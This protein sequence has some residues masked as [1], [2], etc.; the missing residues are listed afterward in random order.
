MTF[1]IIVPVY[2]VK[3]YL[4]AALD[5]LMAQEE[6][7]AE[8]I[9]IDDGSTDGS[10]TILEQYVLKDDRF[11]L[12]TGP[13]GGYGKAMNRG[14]EQA[15]G[16]YIGILEPDDLFVDDCL[17]LIKRR[18]GAD[19]IKGNFSLFWENPPREEE[20]KLKSAQWGSGTPL[21]NPN[22]LVNNPS[23]WSAFYKRSFLEANHI[24]F[25]ET[26]GASFQDLPFF[27]ETFLQAESLYVMED[28]LYRYRQTNPASS[29]KKKNDSQ[30]ILDLYRRIQPSIDDLTK[31]KKECLG[32]YI[33]AKIA[34][35]LD[36]NLNKTRLADLPRYL[37]NCRQ[38]LK[39]NRK[40]FSRIESGKVRLFARILL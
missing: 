11:R 16:E 29:V 6:R 40:D 25:A 39:G 4:P 18:L 9:L 7:S 36:W 12:F 35:D 1:S 22:L 30:R 26:P 32:P 14:L 38:I 3:N 37:K 2:N 31:Q 21:T 34:E 10:L 13:N 23:I 15:R 27:W 5:S 33:T 24:R 28:I 20:Y 8:F 19:I 17:R